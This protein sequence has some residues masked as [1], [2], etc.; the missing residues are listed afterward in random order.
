MSVV[1]SSLSNLSQQSRLS[2]NPYRRHHVGS[3][4]RDGTI[5]FSETVDPETSTDIWE[6]SPAKVHPPIKLLGSQ[7]VERDP[8]ISP[9][10]RWLLYATFD[11]A[12]LVPYPINGSKPQ[13]LG[14][15]AAPRW[16]SDGK[17]ILF[18]RGSDLLAVAFANGKTGTLIPLLRGL[19]NETSLRFLVH[20]D[21]KRFLFMVQEKEPP[22]NRKIELITNWFREVR[23]KVPLRRQ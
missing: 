21:G 2:G 6:V 13:S 12:H 16:S 20:P 19:G 5:F 11:E 15:G 3:W 18:R 1:V 17:E 8:V 7:N 4:H 23:E 9:D 14:L 22:S 10:G